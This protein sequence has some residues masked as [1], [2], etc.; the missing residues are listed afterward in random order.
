MNLPVILIAA[1][2]AVEGLA[3]YFLLTSGWGDAAFFCLIF[4][5]CLFFLSY[6]FKL[7]ARIDG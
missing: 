7:K 4:G 1:G 5:I 2:I 6:R 3:A